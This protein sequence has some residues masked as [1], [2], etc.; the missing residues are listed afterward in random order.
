VLSVAWRSLKTYAGE[1]FVGHA[2]WVCVTVIPVFLDSGCV[3]P[4]RDSWTKDGAGPNDLARD[5]TACIEASRV[6]Y[7][8]PYGAS[9]ASVG[10]CCSGFAFLDT[11]RRAQIDANHLFERCMEARGWR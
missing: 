4:A 10:G 9:V 8:T 3:T 5:R 1:Q 11:A 7:P 2:L 6:P